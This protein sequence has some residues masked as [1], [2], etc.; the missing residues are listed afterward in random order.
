M[1]SPRLVYI[2]TRPKAGNEMVEM[3]DVLIDHV[4]VCN[5][6]SGRTTLVPTKTFRDHYEGM[7]W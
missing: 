3:R 7:K 5:I 4:R 1:A 6:H 2:D